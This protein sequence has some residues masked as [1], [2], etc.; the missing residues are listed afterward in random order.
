MTTSLI[1][2]NI[3]L[4]FESI[5][6]SYT[7]YTNELFR[8]SNQQII[9]YY[10]YFNIFST[11]IISYFNL[12]NWSFNE[13]YKLTW[14]GNYFY[15]IYYLSILYF[16]I[17]LFY[18]IIFP[19]VSPIRKQIF[20]HHIICLLIFY[21]IYFN[22]GDEKIQNKWIL[23]IDLMS[24]ISVLFLTIKNILSQI[25]DIN[26]NH[27]YTKYF[28]DICF[29]CSW[30]IIRLILFTY[31]EYYLLIYFFEEYS[32]NRNIYTCLYLFSIQSL[33]CCLN[34]YWTFKLLSK[35]I[36]K[37]NIL[38]SSLSIKNLHDLFNLFVM[39]YLSYMNILNWDFSNNKIIWTG[40]NNYIFFKSSIIYFFC[41]L[42]WIIKY[43][44][45]T[46][47]RKSIIVHHI[48]CVA[49]FTLFSI[50]AKESQYWGVNYAMLAE[51]NTLFLI[52]RRKISRNSINP[53]IRFC[54]TI[55]NLLFYL[56]WVSIRL[57]TYPYLLVNLYYFYLEEYKISSSVIFNPFFYCLIIHF[58]FCF[59]N[60][61]WT[62]KLVF[63]NILLKNKKLIDKE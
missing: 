44:N 14:N 54:S 60:F 45:I 33:F 25:N 6:K 38:N 24:E 63:K 10:N 35:T 59:L 58:S 55:N 18:L 26:I 49:G 39:I 42:L 8:V 43:P 3:K 40:S 52:L 48:N 47:N 22:N 2:F 32:L 4:I 5:I 9:I 23:S 21:I 41:D 53:I 56:S 50:F 57:I 1:K 19:F 36:K 61:Y 34:Y 62:F 29:Y 12:L 16:T 30:I 46:D 27:N 13:Y 37:S 28:I 7:Y 51:I 31:V 11:S 17:D 20:F 15:H